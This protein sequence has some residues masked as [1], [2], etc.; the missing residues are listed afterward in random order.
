MAAEKHDM[1]HHAGRALKQRLAGTGAHPRDGG[2]EPPP[3]FTLIEPHDTV[4]RAG[5]ARC[6]DFGLR[7]IHKRKE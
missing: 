5:S 2:N 7:K 4:R 6:G 1:P 3:L